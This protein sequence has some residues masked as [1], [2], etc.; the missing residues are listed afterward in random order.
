MANFSV[1]LLW[2]WTQ[3]LWVPK[4]WLYM[5]PVPYCLQHP[6]THTVGC[7]W[8]HKHCV[9]WSGELRVIALLP[10]LVLEAVDRH[11]LLK[12]LVVSG[13]LSVSVSVESHVNFTELLTQV[14]GLYCTVFKFSWVPKR[15]HFPSIEV[16]LLE[17]ELSW[18]GNLVVVVCYVH[19]WT[20][21]W[22]NTHRLA[23]NNW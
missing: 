10:G 22:N 7:G 8:Y 14:E 9:S 3:T 19:E 1:V 11:K 15:S 16:N 23:V 4:C 2:Y 21:P 13:W 12:G 18:V 20:Q 6:E 17:V 5:T